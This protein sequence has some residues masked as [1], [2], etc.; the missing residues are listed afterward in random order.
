M[1]YKFQIKYE[2]I[3]ALLRGRTIAFDNGDF[4]VEFLPPQEGVF[5]TAEEELDRYLAA[6]YDAWRE[7]GTILDIP[8]LDINELIKR[9]EEEPYDSR[10]PTIYSGAIEIAKSKMKR[11]KYLKD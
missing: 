8:A 5:L 11:N 1:K 6:K 4:V 2:F 10:G 9:K 7:L 3:I